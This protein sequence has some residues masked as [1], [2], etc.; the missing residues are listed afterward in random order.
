M[1]ADYQVGK[2]SYHRE[3]VEVAETVAALEDTIH[4]MDGWP[5]RTSALFIEA[6]CAQKPR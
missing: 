5:E 1:D 3:W 2:S 4:L 6:Q